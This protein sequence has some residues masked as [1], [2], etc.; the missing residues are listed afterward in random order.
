MEKKIYVGTAGW[1]YKDWVPNFYPKAQSK[2]FDWLEF[3]AQYFNVVEVNSTYYTY[4]RPNVVNGWINKVGDTSDFLFTVKLHKDF[5]HTREYNTQKARAFQ[6]NLDLLRGAERLGGLLIQFPY[7]FAF[8][9]ANVAY[10]RNL[11]EVFDQYKCFLEVRHASWN[12]EKAYS[13]LRDYN[14][15]L[16][17]IDQPQLGK[18]IEFDTVITSDTLYVR[19]H[20][21][22]EEAWRQSISNYGSKQ[23]YEQQN[24]RYK[25]LYSPGELLDIDRKIKE[26][27]DR[28]SKVYVIMNNHPTGDAV[29]NAFELLHYLRGEAKL[30]I[31]LTTVT[32]YPRLERMAS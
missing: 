18:A 19:F 27:Y 3:Y 5:T 16:A 2:S 12:N 21:R 25:Y 7:S 1:S 32:A 23:T 22:N 13:F 26:A 30:T 29:A 11:F 10:V 4:L 6:Y 24:A 15:S 20:G 31:P 28:I 17:T 9:D 14:V 8:D